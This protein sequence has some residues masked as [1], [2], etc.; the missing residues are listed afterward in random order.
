MITKESAEALG[1][2][3]GIQ[4]IALVKVPQ[5]IIVTEFRRAINC[6]GRSSN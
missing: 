4:A 6:Q 3:P 2:K 5:V 1:I